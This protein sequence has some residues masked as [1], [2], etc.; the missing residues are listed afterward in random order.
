MITVAT[1]WA[2]PELSNHHFEPQKTIGEVS[3]GFWH[4]NAPHELFLH[5]QTMIAQLRIGLESY[6]L[7]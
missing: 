5:L 6:N 7:I 4:Q 1:L 3:A 2:Y